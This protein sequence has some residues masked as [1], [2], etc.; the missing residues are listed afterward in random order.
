MTVT[1]GMKSGSSISIFIGFP[2]FI[3]ATVGILMCMDLLE[4]FLH[5]L[6]LHWVEFMSK[7]F[8][9]DGYR[10]EPLSFERYAEHV[11]EG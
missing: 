9:G 8:K 6:R 11:I 1:G 5:T 3:G 7:F 10:F 4:C 2:V